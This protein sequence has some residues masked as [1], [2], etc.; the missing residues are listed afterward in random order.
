MKKKILLV[1]DRPDNLLSMETILEKDGYD[2]IKA[3]SGRQ[4]LKILL[5]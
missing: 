4:A 5:T 3:D 1:D 2:L